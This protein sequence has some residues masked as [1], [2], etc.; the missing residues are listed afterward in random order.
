[1]TVH[2]DARRVPNN[3]GQTPPSTAGHPA[4]TPPRSSLA[5]TATR[6]EPRSD[7]CSD[8]EMTES[9]TSRRGLSP[10]QSGG[11]HTSPLL[12]LQDRRQAHSAYRAASRAVAAAPAKASRAAYRSAGPVFPLGRAARG[13]SPHSAE[14]VATEAVR[15]TIR[16]RGR[17][18][19]S[20][21]P[22]HG[23]LADLRWL[24][25]RKT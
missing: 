20:I 4:T 5:P 24:E 22:S 18:P 10:G 17:C 15:T 2:T 11:L 19:V 9:L 7:Q 3:S 23:Q 25:W 16:L 12:D 13:S 6:I 8:I 21:V 1:V 14:A